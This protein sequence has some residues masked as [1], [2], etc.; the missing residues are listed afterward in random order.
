MDTGE[1]KKLIEAFYNGETKP[2]EEQMLRNYFNSNDIS[3]ELQ[4]EKKLFLGM[5]KEDPI[6]MPPALE[7]NLNNL[8]DNLAKEEEA[9]S[10]PNRKLWF[11]IGSLAASIAL[12]V[13]AGIYFNKKQETINTDNPHLAMTQVTDE[14]KQK[15]KEAQD[16]LL[17]LSS[18]FN[19]GVD[20]LELVS[21]NLDKTSGILNKTFNR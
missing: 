15:I 8:I 9:K 7:Q 10:S 2:E 3:D 1:I 14:D 21:A 12:L 19:K 13:S 18:N 11:R 4:D 16:A 5:H 17:L 6:E 20:Q